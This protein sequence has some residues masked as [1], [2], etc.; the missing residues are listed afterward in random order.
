MAEA[1]TATTALVA[2]GAAAAVLALVLLVVLVR[3]RRRGSGGQQQVL[4][5][6]SEM[7]TRMEVHGARALGGAR[8]RAG[9]GPAQ[10]VPRRARRVDRPRRGALAHAR[11][12]RRDPGSRRGDRLDPRRRRQADRRDAR[13]LGRGGAAAGD[14]RA[15]RTAT[16][17]ARSRSSTS[18][19]PA[20]EG[21]ELVH[22]GLA[23]PVP[24]ETAAIGFI[25]IYSRSPS[26]RFEEEMIRELEELA[27]RA[28]PAIENALALPRGAAARRPRR[29]DRPAQPALLPRDA[30]ARGR[31]RAALR[32]ASWR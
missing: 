8:A 19:R 25:A 4:A 1:V 13:A 22:S 32:A 9:R 12:R 20:L 27:K 14:L 11:G 6:V 23:V 16:R 29:A 30:R 15:R 2:V 31:A 3:S 10:P 21:A 7:N 18:T 28:G 24:G 26:H 17:R 5:L